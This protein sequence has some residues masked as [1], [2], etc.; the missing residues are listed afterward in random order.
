[1][2]FLTEN[3]NDKCVDLKA[4]VLD[5]QQFVQHN[6]PVFEE[7]P[8]QL[9][10]SALIF[11]PDQSFIWQRFACEPE[12]SQVPSWLS[13]VPRVKK[14][15]SKALHA[16][17]RAHE[18]EVETIY[19]LNNGHLVSV[20]REGLRIWDVD[21]GARMHHF[22]NV[23]SRSQR[24]SPDARY[25]MTTDWSEDVNKSEVTVFDVAAGR[26]LHRL[27]F[28]GVVSDM[29]FSADSGSVTL[30]RGSDP[31]M[32]QKSWTRLEVGSWIPSKNVDITPGPYRNCRVFGSLILESGYDKSC[33]RIWDMNTA[34]FTEVKVE[35]PGLKHHSELSRLSPD[36]RQLVTD[37]EDHSILLFDIGSGVIRTMRFHKERI[38]ILSFCGN[39]R[40]LAS[41]DSASVVIWDTTKGI[42]LRTFR[43]PPTDYR[44]TALSINGEWLA[45]TSFSVPQVKIWNLAAEPETEEDIDSNSDIRFLKF[46]PS[47]KLLAS[48]HGKS[49]IK[50]WDVT[51]EDNRFRCTIDL[52]SHFIKA[53]AIF[54]A[55]AVAFS[56]DEKIIAI[57]GKEATVKL[58]DT[59]T[60]IK[61]EEFQAH[62]SFHLRSLA[63]STDGVFLACYLHTGSILQDSSHILV[64][65][66]AS[67]AVRTE[68]TCHMW[69][70]CMAFS[71]DSG[72]LAVGDSTIM[73]LWDVST[74]TEKYDPIKL[75]EK[76]TVIPEAVAF[77]GTDLLIETAYGGRF[78]TTFKEPYHSPGQMMRSL[79]KWRR[80]ICYG[81]SDVILL[82]P[83]SI[84]SVARHGKLIALGLNG[85]EITFIEID[86][87]W[88]D[89]HM[90]NPPA[91]IAWT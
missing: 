61:L 31:Y 73:T 63:F 27:S 60:G 82:D 90:Q 11:A 64:I 29:V 19:F 43:E 21:T 38:Q 87:S 26:V 54:E 7:W 12:A 75:A 44:R 74:G 53:T 59:C 47:G 15:R 65:D 58:Y 25:L 52:E 78:L 91:R 23:D 30:L 17:I 9:Y 18:Y 40:L 33:Y 46:S 10:C 41:G 39:G 22:S 50:L 79:A 6:R 49:S 67:K 62:T 83:S 76:A 5:A 77:H 20:G 81:E 48:A 56:S 28:N 69:I 32:K 42:R 72:L 89:R 71:S 70:R 2:V 86:T 84:V 36:G 13:R 85:G 4:F 35:Y 45:S 51:A 3:K 8:L 68:I 88:L 14:S 80:W 24:V 34:S 16:I 55:E 1:M 57:C 66:L 37:L